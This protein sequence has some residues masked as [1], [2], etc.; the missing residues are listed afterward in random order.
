MKIPGKGW[1]LVLERKCGSSPVL[2][3]S[4]TKGHDFC[5]WLVFHQSGP[6]PGP[7]P[8]P[9]PVPPAPRLR[10]SSVEKQWQLPRNPTK[11]FL[12]GQL[13]VPLTEEGEVVEFLLRAFSFFLRSRSVP[14]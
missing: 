7:W 2:L 11:A 10:F 5:Q 8:G 9:Q 6:W 13:Q 3:R 4:L 14:T 12:S 1:W